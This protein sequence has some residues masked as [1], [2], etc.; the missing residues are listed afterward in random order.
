MVGGGAK[1][2]QLSLSNS[3]WSC[4]RERA[5]QTAACFVYLI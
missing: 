1:E 4:A 3:Q 2:L 5:R